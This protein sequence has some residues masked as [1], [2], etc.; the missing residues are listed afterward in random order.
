MARKILRWSLF[1]VVLP[2]LPFGIGFV[3]ALYRVGS[4]GDEATRHMQ[5]SL[6]ISTPEILFLGILSGIAGIRDVYDIRST[7]DSAGF[8]E[9]LFWLLL[10][11][12]IV[13]VSLYSVLISSRLSGITSISAN[14]NFA[15]P[16]LVTVVLV[17]LS[18]TAHCSL[19]RIDLA[20]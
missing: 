10:L 5:W 11:S 9:A 15:L 6:L 13:S 8:H 17:L 1:R 4:E 20:K 14:P 2:L 3:L 16:I 7:P 19:I 12:V 18:G